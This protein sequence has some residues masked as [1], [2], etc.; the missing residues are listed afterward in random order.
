M[1]AQAFEGV[2]RWNTLLSTSTQIFLGC[3]PLHKLTD[4]TYND[5]SVDTSP[6]FMQ[7][8]SSAIIAVQH[9]GLAVV[10][11]WLDI[12]QHLSCRGCFQFT[13]VEGQL[14]LPIDETSSGP[15]LQGL[16][17]DTAVLET[18]HTEDVSDYAS[19]NKVPEHSSTKALEIL[20]DKSEAFCDYVL[21][22]VDEKRYK[23]LMRVSSESHSRMIDPSMAML[24]LASK[25]F[26][27]KCAHTKTT[28]AV[29]PERATAELYQFDELLG[30]WGD[31]TRRETISPNNSPEPPES[32]SDGENALQS[33]DDPPGPNLS[34]TNANTAESAPK[35]RKLRISHFLDSSFK[36]NTALA[37]TDDD[38]VFVNHGDS[39]MQCCLSQGT[40]FEDTSLGQGYARW[41]INKVKSPGIQVPNSRRRLQSTGLRKLLKTGVESL[42]QGVTEPIN[43]RMV[44]DD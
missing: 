32:Q 23:L 4:A 24:K 11:P 41:V 21:L 26:Q 7:H 13:I 29:V 36:Y 3:P 12:S 10:A 22:S 20:E 30:R 39:C 18:Q 35:P 16:A 6:H 40:E 19:R 38:P 31:T 27:V 8:L 9:G 2:V 5:A 37:L 42:P 14:G 17:R 28:A 34:A 1:N 25:V 44:R 43:D 15:V 33:I